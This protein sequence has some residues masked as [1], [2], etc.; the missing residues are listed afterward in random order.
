M[1]VW[2][3]VLAL[4]GLVMIF[5]EVLM[6]GFGI[7]GILGGIFLLIS[8]VL[9]ANIYGTIPFLFMLSGI[10]VLFFVMIFLA[11]KSGL[12][13]RVVLNDILEEKDFD[14]SKLIGLVGKVG[15]AHTTLHPMGIADFDGTLVDVCSNRDFIDRGE[16]I[17]VIQVSGKMVV[18]KKI[19]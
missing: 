14:E 7:F 18:I 2:I 15:Y 10:I 13:H 5:A 16:K 6:P 12:Y 4:L 8:T 3:I 11:R 9:V 19:E 17:Q 1:L